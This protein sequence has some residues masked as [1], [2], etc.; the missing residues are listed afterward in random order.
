MLKILDVSKSFNRGEN[1]EQLALNGVS[2]TVNE[3]DFITIIGGNGAGKSTLLNVVSGVHKV[4]AGGIFL[5]EKDITNLPEHKRAAFIGRVFQNPM[6]GTA[7]GMNIEENLALAYRRGQARGLKWGISAKE[8]ELYREELAKLGLGLENMMGKKVSTLS[9]GQRQSLALLMA[10]L[11]KPKLLLLDEHTAA[12]DPK[13]AR[14][15]MEITNDIA[16]RGVTALMVTHNMT[17]AIKTGNRLIMM[18]EGKIIFD[19]NGEEKENL[20]VADLIKKFEL[21]GAE[22]NDRLLLARHE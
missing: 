7:G 8:R 20:Q 9:G 21:S 10:V 19:C 15:I 1:T 5:E 16:G 6:V 11:Q 17:D 3:G 12:L 22:L 18:N 14:R 13:T 2:L 4:D